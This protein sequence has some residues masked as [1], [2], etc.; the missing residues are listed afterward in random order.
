[1]NFTFENQGTST[2]LVYTLSSNEMLDSMSLGMIT[3]NKIPG[4]A[5]TMI[6]QMNAQRYIKYNVS[7]K[8]SVRQFF[9][10]SVSKKRFLGVFKGIVDAMMA[11]EDYMIAPNMLVLDLDYIFANVSTCE[12]S[13][14][15]LPVVRNGKDNFNIGAFFKRIVIDTNYDQTENCD[16][17]ATILNY[18]NS[19]PLFSLQSF[20]ALLNELMD[21]KKAA[22]APQQQQREQPVVPRTVPPKEREQPNN[23][24]QQ[25]SE[26]PKNP[27]QW[28]P[29]TPPQL[30]DNPP[31]LTPQ[32]PP[33]EIPPQRWPQV[34]G[35]PQ[36]TGSQ[37]PATQKMSLF[38]LLQHYN[39]ENAAIYKRQKEE[40]KKGPSNPPQWPVQTL[41]NIPGQE[42]AGIGVGNVSGGGVGNMPGSG[43]GNMPSSGM[44][45][46]PGG[47]MSNMP[48]SGMSNMPGGGMGVMPSGG[49]P[50]VINPPPVGT[51]ANF[52]NTV[53]LDGGGDGGTVVL[54]PDDERRARVL[55]PVLLRKRNNAQIYLNKS[56][57]RIGKAKDYVDYW[58][59]DNPAI[60]RS[61]AELILSGQQCFIVDTNSTNHTYVNGK[62]ISSNVKFELKDG[63]VVQLANEEFT[64]K[65]V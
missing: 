18:L 24:Q 23:P 13:L 3:N 14:I 32:Q 30:L 43:M 39:A 56:P 26:P 22:P 40:K 19:T 33:K 61:H 37:Q 27:P 4:F 47:G 63:D 44:G 52:G 50:A 57:F 31:P 38:Y 29:F 53:V 28:S 35:A 51:P 17:V 34:N 46:M 64:F 41:Y 59:G 42:P 55:R 6:T 58:V 49:N 1:M 54:N 62:M 7:A 45:S 65:L 15:C 36:P 11:A 2:F 20:K 5:S 10:G 21:G 25:P 48:G 8:V 60:S 16:Y 12:T 9:A